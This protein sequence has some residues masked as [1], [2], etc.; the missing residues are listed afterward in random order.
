METKSLQNYLT[1]ELSRIFGKSLVEREWDISKNSKDKITKKFYCPRL[2]IAV[3]PFNITSNIHINLEKI[4]KYKVKYKHLIN[5]LKKYSIISNFNLNLNMNPRCFIAIEIEKSGSRKHM[6]G[7][8]ANSSMMGKIGIV[9]PIGD[10]KLKH[11]KRIKDYVDFVSKNKKIPS[12]Y[13]NIIIIKPE[14][15]IKI[16]KKY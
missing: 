16:L 14:D 2:D 10:E 1:K 3:G 15:F 4:E 11:F 7:D 9:I 5:D 12:K 6:L 8:I 13:N